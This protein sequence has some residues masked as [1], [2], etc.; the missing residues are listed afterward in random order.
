MNIY[1]CY[2]E[3]SFF[4]YSISTE[5]R[6]GSNDKTIFITISWIIKYVN[7]DTYHI[8]FIQPLLNI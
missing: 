7:L 1:I 2:L 8:A 5:V 3:N 6:V 4:S